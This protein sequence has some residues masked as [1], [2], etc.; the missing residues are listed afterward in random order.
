VIHLS[1]LDAAATEQE[2]TDAVA[3]EADTGEG[4][5][6]VRALR[7]AFGGRQKATLV[8]SEAA[9]GR[10]L[11]KETLRV[12]WTTCKAAVR[13]R[14]DKCYRCWEFGHIKAHCKGPSREHL[15]L[16]CGG[17]GHKAR[18]CTREGYCVFCKTTGHQSG[19]RVC[20]EKTN[21]N[22]NPQ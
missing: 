22:K 14:E 13:K 1:G 8:M 11:S 4:E 10:L 19:S 20:R 16:R 9:A 3:K 2:I 12:G 21:K 15:C 18:E 5:L 7:P 17:E 6:E